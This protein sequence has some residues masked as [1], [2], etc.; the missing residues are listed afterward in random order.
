VKKHASRIKNAFKKIGSKIKKGVKK[1]GSKIK[2]KLMKMGLNLA[3][4]IV[5]KFLKKLDCT[6]AVFSWF[7]VSN[8][9]A[10]LKTRSSC[11]AVAHSVH[12]GG[13]KPKSYI[14]GHKRDLITHYDPVD[15]NTGRQTSHSMGIT[16]TTTPDM[17][18]Y[19]TIWQKFPYKRVKKS[20]LVQRKS[21]QCVMKDSFYKPKK[22]CCPAGK[23][24]WDL[25]AADQANKQKW[26][27]CRIKVRIQVQMCS[28]CAC[29]FSNNAV[30][31]TSVTGA[32]ALVNSKNEV[33]AVDT[34]P[35][36][37]TNPYYADCENFLVFFDGLANSIA[38]MVS[39]VL[40]IR[41]FGA[42]TKIG[43]SGS[44]AGERCTRC[45]DTDVLNCGEHGCPERKPFS[46]TQ[47]GEAQGRRGGGARIG[48]RSSTLVGLNGM[49][50]NRAGNSERLL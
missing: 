10:V 2:K 44:I 12:P 46:S 30:G 37:Q 50:S 32:A 33:M 31:V 42:Q 28:G 21:D 8:I 25:P 7:S 45:I 4:K 24:I 29:K 47:L 48:S 40:T 22:D 16:T 5:Q 1:I 41:F 15:P 9:C 49:H 43:G 17:T 35:S 6:D 11:G 18:S 13:T 3:R 39:T 34:S 36:A 26:P 20:A 27:A 38:Q 14:S 19:E 23:M